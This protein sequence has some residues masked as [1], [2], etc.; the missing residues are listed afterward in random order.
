MISLLKPPVSRAGPQEIVGRLDQLFRRLCDRRRVPG[1]RPSSRVREL[2][3]V[4]SRARS[5]GVSERVTRYPGPGRSAYASR[6]ALLFVG[7]PSEA[8]TTWLPSCI[9]GRG[10]GGLGARR[11]RRSLLPDASPPRCAQLMGLASRGC[12]VVVLGATAERRNLLFR[13]DLGLP[14]IRTVDP[15]PIQVK[16]TVNCPGRRKRPPLSCRLGRR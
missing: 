1:V 9:D 5:G 6:T 14:W 8:P 12:L 3:G 16:Q 13:S 11:G 7:T 10:E 2:V 4:G 15:T